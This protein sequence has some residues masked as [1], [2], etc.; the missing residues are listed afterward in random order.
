MSRSRASLVSMRRRGVV[1]AV[2][3]ASG[4]GVAA[5]L[6][7]SLH[8]PASAEL[9]GPKA[10]ERQRTMIVNSLMRREHLSRR[11]L[12]DEIAAR[13]LKNFLKVLDARKIYFNKSDIEEFERQ[14]NEIDDQLRSGDVKFA[15]TVF[16]RFLT[17]L[18]ERLAVIEKLLAGK[19]D[20]ERTE[21]FSTDPDS[22]EWPATAAEVED[23]WRRR[24]KYDLLVLEAADKT[25]GK[26]AIEKLRRRYRSFVKRMKQTDNEELLEWYLTSMTTS[27]D[28]HTT[29][30]SPDSMRN[31]DIILSLKLEGIGAA[32]QMA[33]GVTKVT[34]IIPGGAA[35]KEGSLKPGDRIVSVDSQN[36]GELVDVG[37]MRL[38]DVVKLIRGKAGT[39]VRLG[40]I[41][42][43]KDAIKVYEI[44]R[45][46]IELKDSEAK[47][48]IFDEK[49]GENGPSV[50]IGVINLPSFYMDMDGA[51]RGLENYK[52]TTRDVR[53][54]LED[55]KSKNVEVVVLDL[56]RNG[57]GALTEAIN[58]TGL[59]ID[60]G[61]VVQVKDP[62]G[63]VQHYEDF[64]RGLVWDGPL[65]VLTS[66]LSA[67]A[68]EI[69]AGAIQDYRRGIVVG[70][71][72]THG[73]GT[74]QSLIKLGAHLFRV[75]Q[76]P[77]YGALKITM[78]QFYRP[79]GDSTQ[80][81]GVAADIVLPAITTHMDI[82]EGD[83]DY[84]IP[85][86]KVPAVEFNKYQMVSPNMLADL[87]TKSQARVAASAE[88]GKELK[89][90]RAYL[91]QKK[92]KTISLNHDKFLADRAK[93]DAEKEE[94]EE[95]EDKP[96][97][98]DAPAVE[99]DYYMVE[100][101]DIA[102]DYLA[103]LRRQNLAQAR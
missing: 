98:K 21:Q 77:N 2:V 79:G 45:A 6:H 73:K 102:R 31:F 15:Y 52:S 10:S 59:F 35:D 34:K 19:F 47:G 39:V 40:V 49:R 53:K 78:Q 41:P 69:L 88:F 18:D 97:K 37:D 101:F 1:F 36:S 93:L 68:S 54:I 74:V 61:P 94:R 11:K 25:T 48:Q 96:K 83:L 85:F 29:Y 30:M 67:S 12:D 9:N 60:R 103:Q 84:A 33:D 23:R 99:R 20:F 81:R 71:V 8:A 28:P 38:S 32:L 51:R 92:R 82:A 55:F 91:E 7:F 42:A 56:R 13:T 44:T 62:M 27:F 58:L 95:L 89:K 75:P 17:R 22:L 3:L 24:I 66:K 100:V 4:L 50:R 72:Q 5:L 70:D 16:N 26:E 57:G 46:K 87:R 86:D 14:Q 90:I 65:V 80:K 43:G 76:P 64:D 63:D